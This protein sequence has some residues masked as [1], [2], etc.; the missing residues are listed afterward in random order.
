MAVTLGDEIRFQGLLGPFDNADLIIELR[1]DGALFWARARWD[2]GNSGAGSSVK[3]GNLALEVKNSEGVYVAERVK[4]L[5][6]GDD[7]I[8]TDE[9]YNPPNG[10]QVRARFLATVAVSSQYPTKQWTQSWTT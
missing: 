8:W 4:A 3:I 2:D 6:A 7:T 9:T 5:Y 1:N 10:R